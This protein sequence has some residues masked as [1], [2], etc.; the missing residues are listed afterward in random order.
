[1][2]YLTTPYP[3][4]KATPSGLDFREHLTL[5]VSNINDYPNNTLLLLVVDYTKKDVP[6]KG[7]FIISS[8]R[9]KEIMAQTPG[10]V[11]KRSERT[12]SDKVL[13]VGISIRECGRIAF[14]SVNDHGSVDLIK[15]L[16]GK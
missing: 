15:A 4:C 6:V 7:I 12:K 9:V 2:K 16:M 13:K 14:P 8:D 1:M 5:D 3:P 10:R 11:Y